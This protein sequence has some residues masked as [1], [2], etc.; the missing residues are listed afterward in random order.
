MSNGSILTKAEME[1]LAALYRDGLLEDTLP[2]WINHSPDMEQGGFFFGLNRDGSVVSTDKYMWTH[3][4]FVWLL[5][6]VY[7]SVEARPEWL[8]LARHGVDFIRRHG[9]DSDGRM[10]FS[11]TRDGRPLRKRRYL[12]T[13]SFATIALAAFAKAAGDDRAAQQALDLFKLMIRYHTTPGL[14]DPKVNPKV[15]PG[16]GLAM[17]M[18]LISTAQV[19]RETVDDPVCVEW[20]ERSIEEIERD[21]VKPEFDAVL[22]LVGPGGEF[23][24]SFEG[25]LL[26]P[27]HAIEAG[28]FILREAKRRDDAALRKLGL[29]ILDCSWRKGWD[30]E[31]GGFV[32]YSDAKGL[33]CTEYA[34]DMK[35]WWP[36]NEGIIGA[37]LAYQLTGDEKYA[38]WHRDA[39]DWAY[40]R[41]PDPEHGEW[42]GYLHRD[43]SVSIPL[44]GNNWKGPFHLPRMQLLCWRLLEE[45]QG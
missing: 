18:I 21:F 10:F 15:R 30:D 36:H 43:G 19:L 6:T 9:F 2:F 11:V 41:F 27:G 7:S 20:I 8:E 5:S 12:F 26:C 4:R 3:G 28:W 44:K 16:K 17:P 22:E 45:M 40:A 23:I 29:A 24:D 35:L 34:H 39:H 42:Y 33:P 32:Y 37:L 31:Y 1:R 14:L 25:R 38:Q 13:E